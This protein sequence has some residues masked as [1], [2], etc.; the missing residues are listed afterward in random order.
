M[1][2]A[3]PVILS[4]KND[5]V[6]KALFGDPKHTAP[7]TAFLQSTLPLPPEE[8]T[9]LK[10]VDPNLN[11]KFKGDKRCVLDVR[12]VTRS[13]RDVDV[14]IQ[15][16]FTPDLLGRLLIYLT[17]MVSGKAKAGEDYEDIPQS[18]C[19]VIVDHRLWDDKR[20]HHRFRM[21]D[22]EAGLEYP[23][24]MEIHT[25][26]LPKLP[27]KSDGSKLWRWLKFISSK[28]RDEFKLLAGKD[29][30][31]AEAVDRLVELSASEKARLR[32]EAREKWL[33]DEASRMRHSRKEGLAEGV[34]KV[35]LQLLAMKMTLADITKATGLS[36]VEIKRLTPA[37]KVGAKAAQKP[38]RKRKTAKRLAHA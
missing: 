8:I 26:E 6:F 16:L 30:V 5:F 23:N 38:T 13:G 9:D 34:A 31:M 21:C 19:I 28:T 35:A 7:L 37:K 29:K 18:I 24:L 3:S 25:L 27:V 15:V 1:S 4:P 17:K 33:W 11:R 20:Y 12:V 22:P 2:K 32:A 14:E 10:V 36:A